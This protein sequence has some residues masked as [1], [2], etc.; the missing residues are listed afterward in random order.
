MIEE[1]YRQATASFGWY[2]SRG[3][4]AAAFFD[5]LRSAGTS[6][7]PNV[8]PMVVIRGSSEMLPIKITASAGAMK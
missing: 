6:G 7:F 5:G 8:P 2:V 4:A 3:G 1:Q